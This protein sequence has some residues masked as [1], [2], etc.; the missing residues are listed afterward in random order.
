MGNRAFAP[1]PRRGVEKTV[2][3]GAIDLADELELPEQPTTAAGKPYDEARL[4]VRIAGE[5]IG[6]VTVALG[7]EPLSRVAVMDAIEHDLDSAVKAERRRQEGPWSRALDGSDA[8]RA[9]LHE[10][11]VQQRSVSVVVCTRNRAHALPDCLS[12]LKRLRHD[13]LDFIIVDNAP[14]D[15][16]TRELVVAVAGE[17]PRFRY[18]REPL[19]GLSRARNCGLAHTTSEIIAYTDDDVR[20]DELWVKALL[21][22]FGRRASVGCVTGMVASASLELPAEQYFDGRVW[23]SSRLEAMVYDTHRGP[24]GKAL[25]P[26]A[27]GAFG[28]GANFAVRT[29]L[30]RALGAFDECLGAGSRCDGGEDLDI[31]VRFIRAGYA[32]SYEP[33][34]LVWHEHRASAEELSRQMYS[35]GKSLSAYL[36]KYASSRRSALDILRRLPPGV[37]HLAALGARSQQMGSQTGLAYQPRFAELRGLLVGPFAYARSRRAQDPERRRAVAP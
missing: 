37:R 36:F 10:C 21:R 20:V 11:L 1:Q 16:S 17:D 8:V 6:F 15:D 29:E 26:Y 31:F 27:A 23:W 4:L 2:L 24:L 12:S 5:P 3:S 25:H 34:A 22:G 13:E 33:S 30:V 28:T 7:G 9:S 14:A 19:P 32:I 18:V 35:Y